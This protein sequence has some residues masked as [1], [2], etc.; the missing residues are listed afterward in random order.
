MR[1]QPLL[2]TGPW[3]ALLLAALLLTAPWGCGRAAPR[4]PIRVAVLTTS[5]EP[6]ARQGEMLRLG[7]ELAAREI[8]AAGGIDGARLELVYLEG[9][10]E[11][12][13]ARAAAERLAK[14]Q[15]VALVL[16]PLCSQAAH[17]V[18]PVLD[19]ADLPA[20]LPA[21]SAEYLAHRRPVLFR[22]LP[23][24]GRQARLLALYAAREMGLARVAVIYERSAFGEVVRGFFGEEAARSGLTVV[25]E[26]AYPANGPEIEAM[27]RG[28]AALQPEAILLAGDPEM[29]AVIAREAARLRLDVSF[30]GTS[31]M[32]DRLL[33][34]L[35]GEA[36][37]GFTLA[38]PYVFEP[39]EQRAREFLERFQ[40]A[41]QRRP[42]WIAASAYDALG[43]GAEAIARAKGVRSRLRRALASMNLAA[44]GYQGVTGLT[45]FTVL[46]GNQRPVRVV[47][48]EGGS[49]VPATAQFQPKRRLGR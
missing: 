45:Y 6:L 11:P 46:G 15:T 38:E 40:D 37:E 28:L 29:G 30:L 33:L 20:L 13:A 26:R 39:Q 8:N 19:R 47:R 36:V 35:G 48:V 27:L 2:T 32:A 4:Q 34:D 44:R 7:A 21:A 3:A 17:A 1:P 14:D 41:Y 12:A 24:D 23:S 42:N 22:M 10:C 25:G 49:F 31:L 9:G 43:L 16:G 5:Q 18:E